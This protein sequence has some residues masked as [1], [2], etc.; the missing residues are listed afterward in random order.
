M[1]DLE[2]VRHGQLERVG[3]LDVAPGLHADERAVDCVVSNCDPKSKRTLDAI[4]AALQ[5]DARDVLGDAEQRQRV[6]RDVETRFARRDDGQSGC[7]R[8]RRLRDV[9]ARTLDGRCAG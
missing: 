1:I 7:V 2:R 6:Q 8:V 3:D 4:A 5:A 9:D